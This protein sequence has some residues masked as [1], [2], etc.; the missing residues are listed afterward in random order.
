[1][2]YTVDN[3]VIMAAGY[4][5]RFMPLS[6]ETPKGLLRVRGEVLIE[7]QIRQLREAG[8]DDVIVVTGYKA[9]SFSYLKDA[10]GVKLVHNPEYDVRNNHASLY[11]VRDVLANTYICSSDNY[12]TENPF[13]KTVDDAY[14]AAVYAEGKTSEWCI[15]AD[16]DGYIDTVRIGGQNTW[17]MLGHVFWSAPFSR[18]FVRILEQIYDEPETAGLLWESIFMR[19]L[20]ELKMRIRRYAPDVIF[21]FDTLDEL[22][23]FDR[24]YFD[25][26]RSEIVRSLARQLDCAEHEMTDFR[27]AN[28]MHNG[29]FSFLLRGK[30]YCVQLDAQGKAVILPKDSAD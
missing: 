9:E 1:M 26:T 6:Y 8:V 28:R 19:H 4:A 23:S 3:A 11:A 21:E 16:A 5:S 17:Y 27:P 18:T 2:A 22:R 29:A 30:R 20:D 13:T 15:T 10:F 25:N 14:Y 24:S 12:F 7:R